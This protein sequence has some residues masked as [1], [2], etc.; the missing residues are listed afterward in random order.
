MPLCAASP[1]GAER[2]Q[3]PLHAGGPT[4]GAGYVRKLSRKGLL[5][6]KGWRRRWL[7]VGEGQ[8]KVFK[9]RGASRAAKSASLGE[10]LAVRQ[11]Y[12]EDQRAMDQRG[13]D[14]ADG[15]D[16]A[17]LF[18]V[19]PRHGRSLYFACECESELEGWLGLIEAEHESWVRSQGGATPRRERFDSAAL[20]DLGSNPA[21]S[22]TTW[23][24][25]LQAVLDLHCGHSRLLSVATVVSD[26][27]R[28]ARQFVAVAVAEYLVPRPFQRFPPLLAA[29][30]AHHGYERPE[31]ARSIYFENDV[32]YEVL[33]APTAAAV[34][35]EAQRNLGADKLRVTAA[36]QERHALRLFRQQDEAPKLRTALTIVLSHA[37]FRVSATVTTPEPSLDVLVGANQFGVGR[38]RCCRCRRARR[39]TARAARS[40]TAPSPP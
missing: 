11:L 24:A 6:G 33:N 23:N 36:L 31:D 38:R 13:I 35:A 28:E 29:D 26:F 25:R 10:G 40:P 19:A 37:G 39:S 18:E 1:G 8:L 20:R 5:G 27:V 17:F 3:E 2:E 12:A 22:H 4:G 9:A 30:L 32:L 15:S 16:L 21:D 34:G 7:T 14:T